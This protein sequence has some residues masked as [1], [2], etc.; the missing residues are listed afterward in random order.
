MAFVGDFEAVNSLNDMD[1]LPPDVLA[2]NPQVA[3]PPPDRTTSREQDHVER[4]EPR[5]ENTV[6][7]LRRGRGAVSSWSTRRVPTRRIGLFHVTAGAHVRQDVRALPL[8][9]VT[10]ERS[11]DAAT[12]ESTARDGGGSAGGGQRRGAGGEGGVEREACGRRA[13][14][15][16]TRRRAPP[17]RE[18]ARRHIS[19]LEAERASGAAGARVFAA[20][21]CDTSDHQPPWAAGRAWPERQSPV[22]PSSIKKNGGGGITQIVFALR[23]K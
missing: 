5:R 2:A 15:R 10:A 1:A 20:A 19:A 21:V 13:H 8:R 23:A 17:P 6:F 14:R 16:P 18:D 3:R 22:L 12:P 9:T 7:L 11:I 4:T